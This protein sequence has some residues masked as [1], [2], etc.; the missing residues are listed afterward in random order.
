M[1]LRLVKQVSGRVI[2]EGII[3][4]TKNTDPTINFRVYNLI[5]EE[6]IMI[7]QPKLIQIIHMQL[8]CSGPRNIFFSFY[9]SNVDACSLADSNHKELLWIH[10]DRNDTTEKTS[11]VEA[12]VTNVRLITDISSAQ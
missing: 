1:Y 6:V 5:T 2:S 9:N 3:E 10:S 4:A 12:T 8:Q 7:H 11:G